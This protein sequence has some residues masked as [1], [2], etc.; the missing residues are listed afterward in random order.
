MIF[1]RDGSTPLSHGPERF[2]LLYLNADGAAA[3]KALYVGNAMRAKAIAVIEPG[4]GFG[5]N[6]T[7]FTD[8]Q[9][10]LARV[11]LSNPASMPDFYLSGGFG[12]LKYLPAPRPSYP[13]LLGW[14]S[15]GGAG[16]GEVWGLEK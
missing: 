16:G 13:R 2:S 12:R 11:V 7:D 1:E 8:P 5:G 3:Y 6:W 9:A 14:Y 4:N 10:I 15:Y